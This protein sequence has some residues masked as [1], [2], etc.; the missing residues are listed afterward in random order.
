MT[1]RYAWEKGRF[2]ASQ[3][4]ADQALSICKTS[5]LGA[6]HPGFDDHYIKE[7]ITHLYNV[8]AVIALQKCEY[9]YGLT[10]CQRI[11]H[12]RQEYKRPNDEYDEKW[13]A[14]ADGNIA[15]AL[16]GN[17]ESSQ[18]LPLLHSLLKRQDTSTNKDIY[19]SN[20]CLCLFLLGRP[21][22]ALDT[23]RA[24]MEV[25]RIKRGSESAQ[26]AMWV[27]QMFVRANLTLK[28]I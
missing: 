20:K 10:L 22:E 16:M 9:E 1:F 13:L 25:I 15:V 27:G 11:R 24:A 19:L 17:E 2:F 5:L 26:M 7:E 8:K 18:A 4:I 21:N 28:K 3:A 6:D 12:L 14:F 23:C